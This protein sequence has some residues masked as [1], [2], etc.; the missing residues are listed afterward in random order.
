MNYTV[1]V[2]WALNGNVTAQLSVSGRETLVLVWNV[3]RWSPF[4][5][6]LVIGGW[7]ERYAFVDTFMV[8]RIADL[9]AKSRDAIVAGR[10]YDDCEGGR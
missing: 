4:A 7:M 10:T 5:A 8:A 2:S 6:G 9:L 1:H 3:H